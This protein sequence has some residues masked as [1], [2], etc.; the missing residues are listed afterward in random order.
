MSTT[1]I[2]LGILAAVLTL[3]QVAAIGIAVGYAI[4]GRPA[5]VSILPGVF[6]A[7]LLIVLVL[8]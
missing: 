4:S 5:K 1:Q 8:L 2:I 3:W 7:T 6:A